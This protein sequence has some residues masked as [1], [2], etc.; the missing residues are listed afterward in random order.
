MPA[1]AASASV[2]VQNQMLFSG[3][4]S[5]V[6]HPARPPGTTMPSR[7]NVPWSWPPSRVSGSLLS[8]GTQPRLTST[9]GP[10][11]RSN[12]VMIW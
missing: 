2:S 4:L 3:S 8:S 11:V 12:G 10:S 7:R 1:S 5:G 9:A 6:N